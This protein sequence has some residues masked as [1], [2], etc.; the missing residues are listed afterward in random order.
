MEASSSV[1]IPSREH[2]TG[3]GHG[4]APGA[5]AL[6]GVSGRPTGALARAAEACCTLPLDVRVM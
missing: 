1:V 6:D 3:K 5:A 2:L 4:S